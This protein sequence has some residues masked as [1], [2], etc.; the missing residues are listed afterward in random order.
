MSPFGE[1][2]VHGGTDERAQTDVE[3]FTTEESVEHYDDLLEEGL[4][5]AERKVVDRYY[6]P[7]DAVLNVGCGVG[8]TTRALH[9]RGFDVVGLD[10]SAPLVERARERFPDIEFRVGDATELDA[11]GESYDQV[12]FSYNGICCIRPESRRHEALREFHRV[13]HPG[14]V[15]AFSS[16]NTWY[17]YP[18]AVVDRGF[19]SR[20]YLNA[21]N[22]RRFFHPYKV[23]HDDDGEPFEI[24]FAT[25][26][27]QRRQLRD[28]GFDPVGIVGEREGV[29]RLFETM[30]YYVARKP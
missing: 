4:F 3:R 20:F 27:R 23:G 28:C 22:V 24:Y 14:G 6:E 1:S 7:G 11:P 29:G 19:L 5:E 17:R 12:L 13:L 18:A 8:R 9:D 21:E 25:P 26:W 16:R 2:R 10:A 15:L 30:P